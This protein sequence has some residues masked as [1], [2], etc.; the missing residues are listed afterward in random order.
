MFGH[1]YLIKCYFKALMAVF[2]I[3]SSSMGPD[4]TSCISFCEMCVCVCVWAGGGGEGGRG[5]CDSREEKVVCYVFL[6]YKF[7]LRFYI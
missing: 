1:T 7:V 3:F 4:N 2:L 6:S 5:G